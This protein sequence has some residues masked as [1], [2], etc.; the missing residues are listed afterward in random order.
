MRWNDF[1]LELNVVGGPPRYEW[2]SAEPVLAAAVLRDGLVMGYLVTAL[3][4]ARNVLAL[5]LSYEHED[6][7]NGA[8]RHWT[9][10]INSGAEKGVPAVDLFRTFLGAEG[11]AGAGSVSATTERFESTDAVFARLNPDVA[12]RRAQES[13]RAERAERGAAVPAPTRDQIDAVL[14]GEARPTPEIQARIAALDEATQVRTAPEDVLVA[15]A[16]DPA[17]LPANAAV[18]TVVHEPTFLTSTFLTDQ[19]RIDALTTLILRVTEGTPALYTPPGP[20]ES[21]AGVLLLGRGI[22]WRIT[23]LAPGELQ[24]TVLRRDREA[25]PLETKVR[26]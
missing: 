21:G 26:R 9:G 17:M 7:V 5:T 10:L 24:G 13:S 19:T 3:D 12:R 16:Y 15:L 4:P 2:R 20:G 1:D 11:P 23:S 14:R 8:S 22:D 18:G 6:Y 25:G